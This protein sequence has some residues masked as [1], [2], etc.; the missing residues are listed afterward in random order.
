MGYEPTFFG[1]DG[2]DGILTMEG[3]DASL[4]E[5]VIL[6]TPFSADAADDLTKN[7][8]ATYN[9]NYGE[10][11]N[12][13]AADGYDCPYAIYRALQFYADKN[14]GL[15][16]TGKGADE[17]CEIL[18]SVFTDPAFSSDGVTGN[19]MVWTANGEVNKAPKAMVIE[20][21]VYVGL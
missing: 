11:P 14:G 7:F 3:F 13:F 9:T 2:M 10:T 8:V 17:L 5:G 1:V 20:N 18:I 6:L 19:G 4:A 12:Q 21:G 15:D 16:V